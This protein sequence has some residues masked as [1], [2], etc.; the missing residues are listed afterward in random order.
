MKFR[1]RVPLRPGQSRK[2]YLPGNIFDFS[3]LA[4]LR[5]RDRLAGGATRL[6][7]VWAAALLGRHARPPVQKDA[8]LASDILAMADCLPLDLHG[9]RDR[10]I[11][12][13]GH[14]SAGMTRRDQRR[15]DR[16]RV[17]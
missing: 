9:L 6:N 8:I 10:T 14:V 4:S 17:T 11:L 5:I 3:E 2:E 16:F 1:I 15:R 7:N 13:L 12:R